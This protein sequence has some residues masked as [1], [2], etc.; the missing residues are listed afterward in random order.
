MA[1]IEV[2]EESP[3]EF[4]KYIA[5]YAMH[6]AQGDTQTRLLQLSRLIDMHDGLRFTEELEKHFNEAFDLIAE[7]MNKRRRAKEQ[8][9]Q[10]SSASAAATKHR[11][12]QWWAP[13]TRPRVRSSSTTMARP[14]VS[15]AMTDEGRVIVTNEECKQ[16]RA[17]VT[18]LLY[19]KDYV[20][21]TKREQKIKEL[22][23]TIDEV[24]VNHAWP[25]VIERDINEIVGMIRAGHHDHE[26]IEALKDQLTRLQWFHQ[27]RKRVRTTESANQWKPRPSE[28]ELYIGLREAIKK[29]LE[30]SSSKDDEAINYM[31]LMGNLTSIKDKAWSEYWTDVL[32]NAATQSRRGAIMELQKAVQEQIDKIDTSGQGP[33]TRRPAS[34]TKKS[35]QKTIVRRRRRRSS[36]PGRRRRHDDKPFRISP[37]PGRPGISREK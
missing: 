11:P 29:Y 15:T 27:N 33:Y 18:K 16:I 20:D 5:R 22:L 3:G 7:D 2:D 13:G 19:N 28:K 23:N 37:L 4:A 17:H 36:Q 10:P 30:E 34:G 8:Q 21:S 9:R 25:E 12:E 32:D 35:E 31:V 6:K 26:T 1:D 14:A 24:L